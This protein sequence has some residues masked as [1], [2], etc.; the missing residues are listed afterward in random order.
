MLNA[1]KSFSI[2]ISKNLGLPSSTVYDLMQ[3]TKGFIWMASN[4]GLSRY[5]GFEFITYTSPSQSS[6]PGSTI[7]TDKYGRIW[8]Q[9]FDGYLYYVKDEQ[10]FSLSQN[11]PGEFVP[12]G[13]VQNYLYVVQQDG[14]DVYDLKTLVRLKTIKVPTFNIISST[15]LE[16]AY[17][18][19]GE[20]TVYKLDS[21]FNLTRCD[22]FLKE[23]VKVN[24]MKS[25][26]NE[27][28]LT[29]KNRNDHEL[30]FMDKNLKF[31][32]CV[33][34]DSHGWIVNAQFYNGSY[35]LY[36][37]NGFT[38]YDKNWNK[39]LTNH[40]LNLD[41]NI[42]KCLIDKNGNYWFSSLH[43]GLY[44]ITDF[45]N[46]IYTF[47]KFS[48]RHIISKKDGYLV[49]T[50]SGQIIELD[51]KYNFKKI[52]LDLGEST[53]INHFQYDEETDLLFYTTTLGLHITHNLKPIYYQDI[54]AKSVLKLDH[55]YFALSTS[56][57][58]LLLRNPLSSS[59][60]QKP[61][62]WD[63]LYESG[64]KKN[65][66]SSLKSNLRAK[67]INFHID[68]TR[69]LVT[70]NIGLVEFT[71]D[72]YQLLMIEG[73]NF[74]ANETYSYN[75]KLFILDNL[76]NLNVVYRSGKLS[77]LNTEIG[78][79]SNSIKFIKRHQ[80]TLYMICPNRVFEYDLTSSTSKTY[81]FNT[82]LMNISD[83]IRAEDE[84][85][86]LSGNSIV[87]ISLNRKSIQSSIPEFYFNSVFIQN[88]KVR[89][90]DLLFLSNTQ[91]NLRITFSL[92]DYGS[93]A[94]P[95]ISYRLNKG[96]WIKLSAGARDIQLTSLQ[97]GNYKLEIRLGTTVLKQC[98]NFQIK[99]PFYLR[100]WFLIICMM[101]LCLLTIGVYT[102]RTKSMRAKI[103]VLND[104]VKLEN[105]LR[106][107]MLTSIKAQMN[108]HFFYNALNTIQAYIFTNDKHNATSY[109]AKFSKLTR[110]ILEMS[111]ETT[112]KLKDEL[113]SLDLY[114]QL[115][116]MRFQEDF[117]FKITVDE[118]LDL[119]ETKIPAMLIQPY[120][121]NGV[122]HGLLHKEGEKKLHVDFID[123][124]NYIVVKIEDNGIG[125]QRSDEINR[126]KTDKPRSFSTESNQKRLDLIN[127]DQNVVSVT[128]D[129]KYDDE[130]NGIGTIVTLFISK[131]H[132]T[133]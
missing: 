9:N 52:L 65:G 111:G 78:I 91:N 51:I 26:G 118:N 19:L 97:P 23:G 39:I 112:I 76:G 84:L 74:F 16:D 50:N 64:V 88:Q 73:G 57:S 25:D 35:W 37:N 45:N 125:R 129:D 8:Y 115:E 54:A 12:F 96:E 60:F 132:E 87:T 30:Y 56:G 36:T 46:K 28:F 3:D 113:T 27:I 18:F 119:K 5:D 75:K 11:A 77:M 29:Y 121:E 95:A 117:Y 98:L 92:L 41:G 66:L 80:N 106:T 17:Y 83:M 2:N 108:P 47:E 20:N 44:L 123:E 103:S 105:Q 1:Q 59:E 38:V 63:K 4:H 70:S 62:I 107:S 126:Q 31:Q 104:K 33:K 21:K 90:E 58:V 100:A 99:A 34:L 81:S 68:S 15:V 124:S 89:D 10:M 79:T 110:M 49:S 120:V 93:N 32:K 69:F 22:Y 131:K 109:L 82:N 101:A 127:H 67:S 114:L 43:N 133:N 40:T 6:L 86:I 72:G 13:I 55:K 116:Q 53:M 7:Q 42:S 130:G 102:R 24:L 14:V 85:L 122:K 71:P 94:E 61:S 48:F 128:F